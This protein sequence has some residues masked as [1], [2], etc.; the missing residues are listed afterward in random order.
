MTIGSRIGS[1]GCYN[2][3]ID[4]L[5]LPHIPDEGK[6]RDLGSCI[7]L[8]QARGYKYAGIQ[9]TTMCYGPFTQNASRVMAEIF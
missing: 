8:C 4:S 9:V 7:K 3:N 5:D 1:Q 2:D 6:V